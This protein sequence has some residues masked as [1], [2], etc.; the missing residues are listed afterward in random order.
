MCLGLPQPPLNG[1]ALSCCGYF[2]TSSQVG[3]RSPFKT[4]EVVFYP[5]GE[6]SV[7]HEVVNVL[8]RFGEFQL[9][10]H[11]GHH[12]CRAAS[13]LHE[14]GE[15]VSESTSYGSQ[16]GHPSSSRKPS[17]FPP[18]LCP[19]NLQGWQISSS[20]FIDSKPPLLN[21]TECPGSLCHTFVHLIPNNPRRQDHHS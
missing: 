4:R 5:F 1:A 18:H 12:E 3:L 15:G 8:L 9:P 7:H 14:E 16:V 17:W 11:H 10:G 21:T 20:E 19:P 2:L 13:P 6:L